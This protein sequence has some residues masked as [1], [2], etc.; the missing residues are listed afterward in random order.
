MRLSER[1]WVRFVH[2][3]LFL[4]GLITMAAA[5]IMYPK[6]H[7]S[8]SESYTSLDGHITSQFE[9]LQKLAIDTANGPLKKDHI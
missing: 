7:I 3:C 2:R 1:L 8:E 5:E 4:F 9:E 6:K